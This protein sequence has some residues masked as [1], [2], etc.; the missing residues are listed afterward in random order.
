MCNNCGERQEGTWI[1]EEEGLDMGGI[2]RNMQVYTK[3]F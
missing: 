2:G 1:W 3:K